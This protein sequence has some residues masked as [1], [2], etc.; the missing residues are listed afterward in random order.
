VYNLEEQHAARAVLR[1]SPNKVQE[2]EL[3]GDFDVQVAT[4][5]R[6]HT[7]KLGFS[8]TIARDLPVPRYPKIM[9][10]TDRLSSL[11]L[12]SFHGVRLLEFSLAHLV[13][14]LDSGFLLTKIYW[15][16]DIPAPKACGWLGRATN[17]LLERQ[18]KTLPEVKWGGDLLAYDETMFAVY[19]GL[20]CADLPVNLVTRSFVESTNIVDD[21]PSPRPFCLTVCAKTSEEIPTMRL[22][23]Q[24]EYIRLSNPASW[25]WTFVARMV[26]GLSWSLRTL[27]I[28]DN[29]KHWF[30]KDEEHTFRRLICKFKSQCPNFSVLVVGNLKLEPG[31]LE[32]LAREQIEVWRHESLPD[33]EAANREFTRAVRQLIH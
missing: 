9:D 21:L 25:L 32:L 20:L 5:S 10:L 12:N 7:L 19:L 4:L 28:V 1:L 18:P 31:T 14:L 33:P 13:R 30:H 29:Q 17:I 23:S 3:L 2:L 6:L 15:D 24:F 27:A 26:Q 16:R 22:A 11:E 8:R